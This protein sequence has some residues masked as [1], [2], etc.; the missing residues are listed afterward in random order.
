MGNWSLELLGSH[1]D[2]RARIGWRGLSSDEYTED[3]PYLIAG[4]HINN[5]KIDWQK[6][7][8]LSW[9]RYEE[10]HE[11]ALREQDVV[12]SKDGTIGRVARIDALPG[13]ATL[14]GTMMLVRPRNELDY[15]FL[16]HS[17]GG[18]TFQKLIADRTSGSS[19][20][21]LF[22]RDL[23]QLELMMPPLVEQR[24]IAEVLD[25]IDETIQA[26]ERVIFKLKIVNEAC[27][28]KH[29]VNSMDSNVTRLGDVCRILGGKR[30]PS[31]HS[32]VPYETQYRYLKVEDFFQRS[33][34]YTQLSSLSFSTFDLLKRYEIE[35]G[36]LFISIAGS[37]GYVGV[38]NP[39]V[40]L[41]TILTENATRI[42]PS[43]VFV[44]E[45]L[46][47]QMNSS[48]VVPQIKSEIGTGGGVPKLAL[49][50]IANLRVACP[51]ISEQ[52]EVVR[53]HEVGRAAWVKQ[54]AELEK[55][56]MLRAGLADDLLSGRVRTVAE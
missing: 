11:I 34:N 22:Q 38:N 56:K 46:A 9:W 54:E 19:I 47:L 53:R 52:R 24:Q 44:P 42:V 13:P 21:H 37:I 10:S 36:E 27:D 55:L 48:A 43:K 31:G 35:S 41:R 15:R 25:T 33:V 5:G 17:L 3:G 32:Y 51:D 28:E 16:A 4:K 20:P 45:Y 29:I 26:I 2:V 40:G 12:I 1:A 6:C 50:R 23:V 49:H 39:P 14:N 18:Q 8:R 30:L 7:D